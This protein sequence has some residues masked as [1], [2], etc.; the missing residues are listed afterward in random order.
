M[1]KPGEGVVTARSASGSGRGGQGWSPGVTGDGLA[2]RGHDVDAL[3]AGGV[4]VAADVQ[5]VLGDVFAGQSSGNLLLRLCGTKIAFADVVRGPDWGVFAEAEHV[6]F[7]V[8]AELQQLTP[9]PLRGG[10]AGAGHPR[11]PRPRPP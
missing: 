10:V 6:V 5:P 1:A 4:D 11:H 9:G 7:A 3:F 8:A 2:Q